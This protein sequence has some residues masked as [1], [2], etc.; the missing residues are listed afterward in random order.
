MTFEGAFIRKSRQT[1]T[2]VGDSP[3]KPAIG[4]KTKP[5]GFQR[6]GLESGQLEVIW[7]EYF[8]VPSKTRKCQSQHVLLHPLAIILLETNDNCKND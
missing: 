5:L 3:K 7:F 6:V 8:I 4:D 2:H 1:S